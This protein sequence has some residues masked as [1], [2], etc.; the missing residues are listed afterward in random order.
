METRKGAIYAR[1]STD[2]QEYTRQLEELKVYA[3][4]NNISIEYIFEEK[5]S[6]LNSDRPEYNKLIQLTKEDIDILLIWELSRLSRKS[7]IILAFFLFWI[8]YPILFHLIN[9]LF[10]FFS[11]SVDWNIIR[12]NLDQVST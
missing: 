5:E 6:G 2:R 1:V 4:R 8:F 3:E 7:R 11:R 12:F 10:K 9:Y